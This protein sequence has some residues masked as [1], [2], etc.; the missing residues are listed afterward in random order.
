MSSN[1]GPIRRENR[2]RTVIHTD[3]K[4]INPVYLDTKEQKVELDR[5]DN[6]FPSLPFMYGSSQFARVVRFKLK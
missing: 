1:E 3:K 6:S 2:P 4:I 5:K